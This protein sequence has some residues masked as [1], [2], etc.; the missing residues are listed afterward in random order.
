MALNFDALRKKLNTLKGQNT[1]SAALW[2]PTKGKTTIRIVPWKDCPDNPFIE[3]YFHYMGRKTQLSPITNGNPDPIA[4][5]A[6][7][8]RQT[9]DKDDWKYARQF[10]PKLRTFVPVVV[11]GEEDKGVRFWGFGKTVY[12]QLLAIIDDDDWG[13]ITDVE[14]GFDVGV[15]FIPETESSTN[16]SETKILIKR[17]PSPL[18]GDAAQLETWL[19]TQPDIGEVYEEPT[20]DDLAAYLERYLNPE[21]DASVTAREKAP[22]DKVSE[23]TEETSDAVE[24]TPSTPLV[25]EDDEAESSDSDD[26]SEEFAKLFNE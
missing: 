24:A 13:D 4:E 5:F 9:N 6:D 3:L 26:V 7:S 18:S 12:E 10:S 15:E 21:A 20:Y 2:K 16:Y 8:L 22:S 19:T 17:K 23:E 25:E 14:N 1:R 11:R